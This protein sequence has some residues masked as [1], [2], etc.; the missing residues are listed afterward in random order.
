[1]NNRDFRQI[2]RFISEI[3]QDRI[4]IECLQNAYR[5]LT[6]ECEFGN[7]TNAFKWYHPF[8]MSLSDL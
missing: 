1:M 7:R 6:I 8:S 3:V 2:S 5:M 4:T